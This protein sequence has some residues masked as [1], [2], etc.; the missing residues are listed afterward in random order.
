VGAIGVRDVA[1]YVSDQY[2]DLKSVPFE[3]PEFNAFLYAL[4]TLIPVLDLGQ[5]RAWG[6]IAKA[7]EDVNCASVG[8]YVWT[9]GRVVDFVL[10]VLYIPGGWLLST[11]FFVGLTG[12]TKSQQEN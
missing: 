11:L 1:I 4:D 2:I 6:P 12:L 5:E 9:K 3:Y 10:N 8:K 7:C